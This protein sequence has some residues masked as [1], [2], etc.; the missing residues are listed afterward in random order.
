[1]LFDLE[2]P[3]TSLGSPTGEDPASGAVVEENA[4]T[5]IED[6]P[7]SPDVPT[8]AATTGQGAIDPLTEPLTDPLTEP[9]TNP[10]TAALIEL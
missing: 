1:V 8:T 4:F 6:E 3:A 5:V 2:P 7:I 9:L 10:L